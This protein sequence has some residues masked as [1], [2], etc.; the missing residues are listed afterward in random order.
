MPSRLALPIL[1][2]EFFLTG[3][4]TTMLGV[5]L[6]ILV[7]SWS[8]TDAQAGSLFA[9]Q[10]VAQFVGSLTYGEISRRLGNHRTVVLGLFIIGFGVCGVALTSWSA[11]LGFVAM[12]GLGLGI[13][14]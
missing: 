13:A 6:P 11:S 9:V 3:I 5:L 4:A 14:L 1:H 8:I 2:F 12:Y 10:F 7:A